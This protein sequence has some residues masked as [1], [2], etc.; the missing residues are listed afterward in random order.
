MNAEDRCSIDTRPI[1]QKGWHDGKWPG[2]EVRYGG[3]VTRLFYSKELTSD[4]ISEG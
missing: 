1:R 2:W 3:G 4:F